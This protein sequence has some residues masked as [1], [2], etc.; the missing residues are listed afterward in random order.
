VGEGT[1]QKHD[2]LYW[3][4]HEGGFFQS[5]RQGPWKAVRKG[6]DRPVELYHL[7]DDPGEE[8]DVAASEP[9]KVKAFEKILSEA[10]TDHPGWVPK[11]G[12]KTPPKR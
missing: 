2:Y 11:E 7:P 3:E 8:K 9:E 10:R 1:Q 5:V 4:F 12:K 6:L